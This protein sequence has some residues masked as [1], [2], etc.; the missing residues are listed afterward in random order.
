[1]MQIGELADP[2]QLSLRT[3]RHYDEIGLLHP[4]ARTDGGFRIYSENDYER[5]LLIRQARAL[6]FSLDEVANLLDTLSRNRHARGSAGGELVRFL[7]DARVRREAMAVNLDRADEFIAA[8]TDR[9][10]PSH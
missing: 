4:S 1:M 3:I 10:S 2:A 9:V 6:G 8:M 5:L 7:E